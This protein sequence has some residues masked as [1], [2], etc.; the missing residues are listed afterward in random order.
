MRLAHRVEFTN[1]IRPACLTQVNNFGAKAIATGWGSTENYGS[2]SDELLKVQLDLLDNNLCVEAFEDDD[3][4]VID[5][6]QIC[7]GLLSGGRDTCQGGKYNDLIVPLIKQIFTN[8]TQA[9]HCK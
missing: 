5:E 2:T 1:F 8:Q 7:A 4:V 6:D 9:G 3:D